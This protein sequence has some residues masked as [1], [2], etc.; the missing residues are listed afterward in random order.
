MRIFHRI[1]IIGLLFIRSVETPLKGKDKWANDRSHAKVHK[2][3]EVIRTR[4]CA[5]C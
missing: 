4:V 3:L 1:D 5:D 2:E